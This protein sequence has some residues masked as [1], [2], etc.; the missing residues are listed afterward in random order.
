MHVR[1]ILTSCVDLQAWAT[2]T[3]GSASH[4]NNLALALNSCSRLISLRCAYPESLHYGTRMIIPTIASLG[5][6]S[7]TVRCSIMRSLPQAITSAHQRSLT[8]PNCLQLSRQ[9]REIL[10]P[11]AHLCLEYPSLYPSASPSTRCPLHQRNAVVVKAQQSR[12][13]RRRNQEKKM[14]R[15]LIDSQSQTSR[16]RRSKRQTPCRKEQE[17]PTFTVCAARDFPAGQRSRNTTGVRSLMIWR[18][19]AVVGRRTKS[20]T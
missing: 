1:H 8:K 10:P 5:L 14:P 9:G 11:L 16:K 7:Q 4:S 3:L 17:G 13:R 19:L 20:Q 12:L 18:Q 2:S 6:P 15:S